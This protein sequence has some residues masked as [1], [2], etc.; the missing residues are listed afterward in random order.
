VRAAL[1]VVLAGCALCARGAP[2]DLIVEA[3][4]TPERVYVGGEA[5]LR[6]RLLRA[7][8]VPHGVL[9]PPALGD[10]ADTSL[11]GPIRTYEARRGGETYE[12]LER[13]YVIVPRRAGRLV[14]PGAEFESALRY[15]EVFQRDGGAA[16][17][18]SRGPERVLEVR[19]PPAGAAEPWLPA[20]R[21]TLE[22]SWSPG[23]GALATGTPVTRT[24]VVRAEGLAAPQL[25]RLAMAAHPALI[26]HHDQPELFT[27]FL[28]EGMTGRRVQRIVLMP[29]GDAVI[30]LP[31]LNV[32]WWDVRA[33]APR[34]AT[35]P[36]WKLRV[37]AAIAPQAPPV[38]AAGVSPGS[39]LRGFAAALLLISV[40][41]LWLYVRSES[42]REA[43]R[44]LR[45]ACRRN[46]AR[47]ARDA[48]REWW[49]VMRPGAAAPLL[50]RMGA[51][52]DPGARVQLEALDAALYAG[53][54]W[55]GKEF[56]RR[57][58]PWLREK[59]AR[60]AR[61]APAA[62]PPL[63]RLQERAGR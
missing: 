33:D 43:R 59:P 48:L 1:L 34:V 27:E 52:W 11:L 62:P 61:R 24:I 21:V 36:G 2:P 60:R 47:A 63:F 39:M 35:L 55:E 40:L 41:A 3:E 8:G 19:P 30:E 17:R 5:R 18:T 57:V 56:W 45:E 50:Q 32:R 46:D 53:R 44:A 6:L 22:E 15:A 26:L 14:L 42:L 20:R 4:L 51:D 37:G 12:V 29:A 10:A 25:P 13:T 28:A 54:A 23:L 31:E 49:A 58:R 7:P 9:R 38:A 16:P